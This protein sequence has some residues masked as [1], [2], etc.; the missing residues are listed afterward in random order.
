MEWP[1]WRGKSLLNEGSV[2]KNN[3]AAVTSARRQRVGCGGCGGGVVSEADPEKLA[4]LN[5][6]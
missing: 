6:P 1:S 3:E 2:H 4:F 5:C